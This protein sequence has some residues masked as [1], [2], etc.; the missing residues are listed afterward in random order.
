MSTSGWWL[1][2]LLPVLAGAVWACRA[3]Q[4]A[5]DPPYHVAELT[6]GEKE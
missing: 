2:L 1:F 6:K 3:P 4:P 5:L